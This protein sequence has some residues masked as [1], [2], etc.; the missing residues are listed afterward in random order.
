MAFG[1][2]RKIL[3]SM[4]VTNN[5]TLPFPHHYYIGSAMYLAMQFLV[6]HFIMIFFIRIE[7]DN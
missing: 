6:V 4:A 3:W 5:S 7:T 2:R 1:R